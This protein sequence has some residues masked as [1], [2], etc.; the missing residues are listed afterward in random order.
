MA[1][2]Y[3][4]FTKKDMDTRGVVTP[5]ESDH[6]KINNVLNNFVNYFKIAHLS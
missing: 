5:P 2:V 1:T 3:K 4:K 6:V